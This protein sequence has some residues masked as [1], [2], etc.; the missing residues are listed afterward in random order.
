MVRQVKV[1][2]GV[3]VRQE[4]VG[5]KTQGLKLDRMGNYT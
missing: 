4:A 3:R 5:N 2:A 1:S